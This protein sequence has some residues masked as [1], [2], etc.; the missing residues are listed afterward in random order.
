MIAS[1]IKEKYWPNADDSDDEED[2]EKDDNEKEDEEE[3][4]QKLKEAEKLKKGDDFVVA[5]P[6]VAGG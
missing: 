5:S 2:D 3:Q 6:D 1:V 4:R